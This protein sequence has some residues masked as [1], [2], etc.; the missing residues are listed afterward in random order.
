MLMC[1]T[2]GSITQMLKKEQELLQQGYRLVQG[3]A[4]KLRELKLR[5]Y[6]RIQGP[7]P[8]SAFSLAWAESTSGLRM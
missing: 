6:C 2:A 4:L 1:L 8:W 3:P 5:E 7:Y